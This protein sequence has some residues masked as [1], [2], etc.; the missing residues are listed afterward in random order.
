MLQYCTGERAPSGLGHVPIWAFCPVPELSGS[1]DFLGNQLKFAHSM[2][3]QGCLC[4]TP[5]GDSH[6]EI[7]ALESRINERI[8]QRLRWRSRAT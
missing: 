3:T 1:Q 5:R 4:G 2:V 7:V 6:T 8:H